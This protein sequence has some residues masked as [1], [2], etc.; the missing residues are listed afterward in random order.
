[1]PST[2]RWMVRGGVQRATAKQVH[3]GHAFLHEV[4]EALFVVVPRC[5]VWFGLDDDPNNF[6]TSAV[7]QRTVELIN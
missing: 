6:V 7:I 1:V 3:L 2:A 4:P 5:S